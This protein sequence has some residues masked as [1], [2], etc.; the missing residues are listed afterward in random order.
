MGILLQQLVSGLAL[1]CV[2]G[3]IA[4]GYSFLFNAVGVINI[5]QGSFVMIG[6]FI[7]G[8]TL[9]NR[10][11]ASFALSLPVL[12][13]SMGLF[14]MVCE[15]F[16]FRPFKRAHVRTVLVSLVALGMLL[17]N[18][19]LI[20]W[21]AYPQGTKGLFGQT[22]I[23]IGSVS[24]FYQ[25]IF[26][27]VA[28]GLLLVLQ[29]WMFKRTIVGKVMRAVALDRDTAALMGVETDRTISLIFAYSSILGGLAGLLIAPFYSI[30]PFLQNIGFK[31]FGACIIGSFS[32]IGGAMAGGVLLGLVETM[33]AA[34]VS[35]LYKDTIAFA[36]IITFLIL[37]PEGLFGTRTE[38]SGL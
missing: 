3:L 13:V 8:V 33:G 25:S 28:T 2:Y 6:A 12:I 16:F 36:V 22:T 31:G 29:D 4:L 27:I 7:Y 35:S 37:R 17:G 24:I 15:R 19:A 9:T 26:I 32:S 10:L 18:I 11:H 38:E 1:G 21:G 14:G 34:Y 23:H 20:I 30:D 5:A